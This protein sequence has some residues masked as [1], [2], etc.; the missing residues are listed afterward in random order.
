MLPYSDKIYT[1]KDMYY[2]NPTILSPLLIFLFIILTF[3]VV[4][5]KTDYFDSKF[6]VFFQAYTTNI[7]TW[8]MIAIST[9]G[10]SLNSLIIFFAF[11]TVL[12]FAGYRKEAF[13]SYSIWIGVG[14]SLLLK[15]NIGRIRPQEFVNADYSLPS[16][17]SYPSGHVVFYV[18]FFG[19]VAIYALTLPNL[20]KYARVVL[21]TISASL[22]SLVGVSRLYLGVHWPTDVIGGYLLGFGLLILLNHFY[23]RYIFKKDTVQKG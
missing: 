12:L 1:I 13:F 10:D 8:I 3:L 7:L 5:E 4:F 17:F 14:M 18:L 22:I 15:S 16:D 11:A 9:F 19:I 20:N 6:I 23:F 2:R 21:L